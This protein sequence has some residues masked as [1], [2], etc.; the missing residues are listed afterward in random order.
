MST[1][2]VAE[3]A[4]TAGSAALSA[5]DLATRIEIPRRLPPR[6]D[7]QPLQHLSHSS[8]TRWVLC[9]ELWRRYYV[10]GERH[11]PT[12]S[13][14]LGRRV[15][16]AI[17]LYYRR[18]L[19][20]GER[21]SPEQLKDAYRDTWHAEAEAEA[22]QLGIAWEDDLGSE[23]AFGIGLDAIELSLRELVPRLGEPVAV[24]RKLEFTLTPGL[25]WSVSRSR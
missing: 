23:R 7:G 13:M 5:S 3:L 4:S 12:G 22:E 19:E 15:D 21:L 17:T 1:P 18:I 11:A 16:D 25:E 9:P 2:Q 10:C 14:F 20:H 24:Q 6:Y 8:Y